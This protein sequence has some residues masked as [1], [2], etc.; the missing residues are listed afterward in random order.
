MLSKEDCFRLGHVAKLRGFKGEVSIFLDVDDP[1]EYKELES[2]FVEIDGKLIPFFLEQIRI[3]N[4]GF[5]AVK[6]EKIDSEQKAEKLRKCSLFL[7]L[8][9]LPE[10]EGTDFYHFE[11]AGFEVV[12]EKHGNI[13]IVL[14]V[15]DIAGNPIIQ[16]D[17]NGTEILIPN[18]EEFILEIDRDKQIIKIKA[19]AG[20]IE[21]YLGE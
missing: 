19:P 3:Q 11:I 21:M 16:I 5:A 9:V 4:N 6:F 7:P 2:V 13:G 15:L 18:Q 1:Y 20:L 12:D 14:G 10:T 17:Q 8:D